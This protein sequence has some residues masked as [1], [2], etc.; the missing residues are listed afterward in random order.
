MTSMDLVRAFHERMGFAADETIDDFVSP[1]SQPLLRQLVSDLEQWEVALSRCDLID[2]DRRVQRLQLIIEEVAE[3]VKALYDFDEIE[4]A[5]AITDLRYVVD[6]TA[7]TYGMPLDRLVD[8]V[9]RSNMTKTPGAHKP[10]KGS[11]F[12]EPDIRGIL[13][14]CRAD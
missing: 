1:S 13:E 12:V 2:V 10:A 3:L 11:E 14:R 7:V 8:E 9:H 6:G 5:D 4:T